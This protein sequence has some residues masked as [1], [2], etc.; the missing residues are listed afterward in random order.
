[1]APQVLSVADDARQ[2]RDPQKLAANLRTANAAVGADPAC[3]PLAK[4]H[5]RRIFFNIPSADTG[6]IDVFGLGYEE[7]DEKGVPVPG[8]FQDVAPFNPDTPTVCVPLGPGNTPVHERWQLVNIA[9]EDH[10][11]HIH[12]TKFSILTPDEILGTHLP[13]YDHGV[14]LHD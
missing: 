1:G 14:M 3:T 7:L 12:Q 4:G 5:M 8:T 11:F 10:N 9:S 6:L 2:L 13:R